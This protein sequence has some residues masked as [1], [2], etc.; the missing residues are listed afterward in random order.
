ML[1]KRIVTRLYRWSTTSD[2][3]KDPDPALTGATD[4]DTCR[5]RQ[6]HDLFF[7]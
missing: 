4:F 2:R 6:L 7:A 1:E 5:V 3:I